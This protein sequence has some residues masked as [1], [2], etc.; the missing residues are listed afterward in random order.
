MITSVGVLTIFLN[1]IRPTIRLWAFIKPSAWN[2]KISIFEDVV[3]HYYTDCLHMFLLE[4][5]ILKYL[6]EFVWKRVPMI[7]HEF[8]VLWLNILNIIM[9]IIFTCIEVYLSIGLDTSE[10]DKIAGRSQLDKHM[11]IYNSRYVQYVSLILNQT[12]CSN[13]ISE[14]Q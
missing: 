13:L 8:T 14:Y 10:V 4:Y 7:D 6:I 3:R 11:E 12:Y 5:S 9:G 1:F 2:F